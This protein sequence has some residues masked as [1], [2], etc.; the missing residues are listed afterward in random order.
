[1]LSKFQL[2]LCEKTG[3]WGAWLRRQA[4]REPFAGRILETR[5]LVECWEELREQPAS[6][7]VLELTDQNA[8]LLLPRLTDLG[9]LYPDA[10]ALVVAVPEFSGWR[11]LL[12]EAGAVD[13]LFAKRHVGRILKVARRLASRWDQ[14]AAD[15]RQL[16]W[17]RLPWDDARGA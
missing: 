15:M 4:D 16:V 10:N 8:E 3:D 7:L 6:L 12:L 2:L 1:M 9:R 17:S 5:S 13:A 11:S 14:P